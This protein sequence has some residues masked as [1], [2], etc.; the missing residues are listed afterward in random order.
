MAHRC[1]FNCEG[2]VQCDYTGFLVTAW[3]EQFRGSVWPRWKTG[4]Q[5]TC[6]ASKVRWNWACSIFTRCARASDMDK[7]SHCHGLN[8]C[9]P[10]LYWMMGK[11]KK[12]TKM[13]KYDWKWHGNAAQWWVAAP[14]CRKCPCT[15]FPSWLCCINFLQVPCCR[16]SVAAQAFGKDQFNATNTLR[17]S[18]ATGNRWK[19]PRRFHGSN[20]EQHL[21]SSLIIY[22]INEYLM[23]GFPVPCLIAVQRPPHLWKC[24]HFTGSF[25]R[26]G[27]QCASSQDGSLLLGRLPKCPATE[28]TW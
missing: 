16:P 3:L 11:T 17:A 27:N 14:F 13:I 22:S 9:V 25:Q 4:K 10:F 5:G 28:R 21:W 19:S 20:M 18:M 15:T 12:I 26:A 24:L 6:K 23:G 7:W 1:A 8:V 2:Y